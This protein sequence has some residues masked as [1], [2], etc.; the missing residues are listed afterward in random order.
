MSES[1]LSLTATEVPPPLGLASCTPVSLSLFLLY[2]IALF[3][4]TRAISNNE[5]TTEA[6]SIPACS[7]RRRRPGNGPEVCLVADC[8]RRSATLARTCREGNLVAVPSVYNHRDGSESTA[9]EGEAPAYYRYKVACARNSPNCEKSHYLLVVGGGEPYR[10]KADHYAQM[11]GEDSQSQAWIYDAYD[12][13]LMG[14]PLHRDALGFSGGPEWP[15]KTEKSSLGQAWK[16]GV[17]D[18]LAAAKLTVYPRQP[19]IRWC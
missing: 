7:L 19:N 15:P 3:N 18:A 9:C 4:L 11:R 5:R 8:Y 16:Q 2:L 13:S 17:T 12:R 10:T 6:L 1:P 14:R